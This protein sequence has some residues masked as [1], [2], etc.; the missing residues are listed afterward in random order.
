MPESGTGYALLPDV[1]NLEYNGVRF[2]CL[3]KSTMNGQVMADQAERTTK[4]MAYTLTVEGIITLDFFATNLDATWMRI[5]QALS[6]HGAALSYTGNGLG[7]F[8][9]NGAPGGIKDVA[10]GPIP[11]V[12]E[13]KNLG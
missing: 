13:M 1:G 3:Y 11:K 7:G 4:F 5:R 12:L 2:S 9:M 6:V 10:W 8:V